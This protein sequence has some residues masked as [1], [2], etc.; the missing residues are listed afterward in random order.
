MR[1][2]IGDQ[3]SSIR[4]ATRGG[5]NRL[6]SGNGGVPARDQRRRSD[7][8]GTRGSLDHQPPRLAMGLV[9]GTL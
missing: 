9:S 8:R 4:R 5:R 1:D 6:R 3:N 7:H 2:S